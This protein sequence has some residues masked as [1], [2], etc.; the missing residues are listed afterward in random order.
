VKKKKVAEGSETMDWMDA[1][2]PDVV[3]Y[4][5]TRAPANDVF[6]GA[7]TLG[8]AGAGPVYTTTPTTQSVSYTASA[9]QS[10]G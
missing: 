3:R 8:V 2:R 1:V 10:Q 6:V 9:L 5:N 7:A 4:W